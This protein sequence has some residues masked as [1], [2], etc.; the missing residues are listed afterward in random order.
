MNIKD[1]PKPGPVTEEGKLRSRLNSL[2]PMKATGNKGYQKMVEVEIGKN[3]AT[4]EAKHLLRQLMK[5]SPYDMI[6]RYNLF[7][8]WLKSMTGKEIKEIIELENL[9]QLIK[10]RFAIEQLN[11]VAEGKPLNKLDIEKIKALADILEKLNTMKY[12]KKNVN[13]NVGYD[14]IW[15]HMGFEQTT[16]NP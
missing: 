15:K 12:G 10:D 16:Q 11:S 1:A 4:T 3:E 2:K 13:V 5:K 6:H 9:F 8:I 7:V 14:D